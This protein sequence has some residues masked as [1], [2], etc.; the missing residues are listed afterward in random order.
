MTK[1]PKRITPCPIANATVE[2]RFATEWDVERLREEVY[3]RVKDQYPPFEELPIKQIPQ[4][5][6]EQENALRYQPYYQATT[7]SFILLLGAH[8][9]SVV[10]ATPYLGWEALQSECLRIWKMV[11]E[12]DAVIK[13]ERLGLRYVNIFEDID[14]FPKTHISPT[15]TIEQS[16]FKQGKSYFRTFFSRDGFSCLLQVSNE[17]IESQQQ[18]TGSL[19][20]I[21]VSLENPPLQDTTTSTTLDLAHTIEKELFF[22]LLQPEFLNTFSPEY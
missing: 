11:E 7:S 6:L 19:I 18:R 16:N 3:S 13:I 14:V 17:L 9:I 8:M 10:N 5:I 15:L 22:G 20:D 1:I 12:L 21:D 4:E 2:F